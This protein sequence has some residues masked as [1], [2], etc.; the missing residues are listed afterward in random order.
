MFGTQQLEKVG[1]YFEKTPNSI[2]I[3]VQP[4]ECFF[5]PILVVIIYCVS[6]C[7]VTCKVLYR[8]EFFQPCTWPSALACTC[9][10]YTRFISIIQGT[11]LSSICRIW[12]T[13]PGWN[14]RTYLMKCHSEVIHVW[15]F[16]LHLLVIMPC[17]CPRIRRDKVHVSSSLYIFYFLFFAF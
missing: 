3:L 4:Q 7:F 16:L 1:V 5:I 2:Y 9:L 17:R 12:S 10:E 8:E 15:I 11:S 13:F 14:F 6:S